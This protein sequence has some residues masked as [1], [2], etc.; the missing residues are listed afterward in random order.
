M[1]MRI[2]PIIIL[3]FLMGGGIP[4]SEGAT[5]FIG[6]TI[7]RIDPAQQTITFRTHEGQ[8]WTLH[9]ADPNLLTKE[10]PNKGDQVS[11]ETDLDGKVTKIVKVAD[12]SQL[13]N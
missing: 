7:Q 13:K 2:I 5:T 12:S 1:K 9:V 3:L 10:P 8:S 11:L 4:T 6:S